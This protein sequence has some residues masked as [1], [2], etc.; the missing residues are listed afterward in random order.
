MIP[1]YTK[2]KADFRQTVKAPKFGFKRPL[3]KLGN[4]GSPVTNYGFRDKLTAIQTMI[5]LELRYK[6]NS[7]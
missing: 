2:T 4:F 1:K 3:E 6:R 5:W 7:I